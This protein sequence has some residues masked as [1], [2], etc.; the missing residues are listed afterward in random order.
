MSIIRREEDKV[1]KEIALCR[2]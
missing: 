1:M 2:K